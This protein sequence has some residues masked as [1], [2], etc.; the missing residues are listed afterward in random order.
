MAWRMSAGNAG[1]GLSS[2]SFWWRRC[3]EQSRSATQTQ[4]PWVSAM[5][6]ISMWRGQVR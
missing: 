2:M 1:A 4:L 3:A 6:C 5:T